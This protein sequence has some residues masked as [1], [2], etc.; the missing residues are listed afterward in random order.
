[1]AR[2]IRRYPITAI[3]EGVKA[4][5]EN[6]MRLLDCAD[7]L[8]NQGSEDYAY[9]FYSFAVEEFGKAVLLR[10]N[11]QHTEPVITDEVSFYDHREKI[12][13]A[14]AELKNKY[15]AVPIYEDIEPTSEITVD[16]D[17]KLVVKGTPEFQEMVQK[18][19][20]LGLNTRL[21]VLFVDYNEK[22]KKW[23]TWKDKPLPL[24]SRLEDSLA[25]L[26]IEM[27]K[28]AEANGYDVFQ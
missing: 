11:K 23:Q 21:D 17:G 2:R 28:W 15:I 8:N 6:S 13:A 7:K 19:E 24:W 18:G 25:A 5:L 4:C 27:K 22:E 1:M 26:K 12:S 9:I 3:D 20:F 16:D 14:V 10:C